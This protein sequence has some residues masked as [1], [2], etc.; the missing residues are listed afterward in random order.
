MNGD[1]ALAG[2]KPW[3]EDTFVKPKLYVETTVLN[4]LTA[5]PSRDL[6]VAGHQQ[7]SQE[8]WERRRNG[9]SLFIS[10][11]VVD[12]AGQGDSA[13]V[14]R[15]LELIAGLDMLELTKEVADLASAILKARVI[16]RTSATDA[17][18]IAVASVH[19]MDS[20]MTWNCAHIANAEIA[21]AVEAVCEAQGFGCPVICTPEGLLGE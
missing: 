21:V 3:W 8:W 6:I 11:L 9:F 2:N 16:P 10:Q 12:E 20:L 4:Y 7:V 18:H 19:G 5:R 17:A 13:A 15:R 1:D 14:Q